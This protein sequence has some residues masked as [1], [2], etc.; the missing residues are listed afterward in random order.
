MKISLQ[1]RVSI[2]VALV[3]IVISCLSTYLFIS[4][5]SRSKEEGRI[6]RGMAL[7]YALSK[8]AEEGLVNEDLDLIKK[9]SNIIKSQDVVLVQVYSNI[10]ESIDSYPFSRLKELPDPEALKHFKESATPFY[11]RNNIGYD[12]YA[13][14][15][16]EAFESS[17]PVTIGFVRVVLSSATITKEIS[18]IIYTNIIVSVLL[19]LFAIVS[20]NILL[21]RL[22]IKPVMGLYKSVSMFKDGVR[23]DDLQI[24]PG[25]ADEIKGLSVE[26]NHMCKSIIEKEERL[27]ESDKRTRSLFER[28]EHGIFRLDENGRIIEANDRFV[29]MFG[30][31][32]DLC[33]ILVGEMTAHHCLK[34][35][36]DEKVFHIEDKAVG[37]Y[38]QE[39]SISLSLYTESDPDGNPIGFDGYLIDTTEKKRLE[40][41]LIRSQK[42]EAVGTL[43]GGMAHDFNNILTA[44]LGYSEIILL[45]TEEGSEFYKPASIIYEAA[46]RGADFGKKILALTRKE[47]L[48]TRSLNIN[49]VVKSS[50]EILQRSIH[51]NIEIITNLREEIPNIK[52][53]LSQLQQVIL[54]LAVNARDAM[55]D[56]GRLTIET[57]VV[58]DEDDPKA[59]GEKAGFVKLS[60]SDTG[61]GMDKATQ[62]HIFDPFFTTKDVG[63]GTGLGLYIVHSIVSN[64]GG[65]INFYSEPDK[66]TQF[67]I[68]LPVTKAVEPEE[69]HDAIN[70]QGSGTILVIDDETFIREMCRDMLQRLGYKV[71]LAENGPVGISIFREMKNEIDVVILDM[72][73]PVM[74]GNEVFHTLKIIKNDAKILLCSGY[75]RNGFAGIDEL[76]SQGASGFIQKPF[77]RRTMAFEIKKALSV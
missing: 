72:V 45:M 57:S 60:I 13:P 44:I 38:G 20:I 56:G 50:I 33:D 2:I 17:P 52:A 54:N 16:F 71:I 62:G 4:M 29:Q 55:L 24:M 23:P 66:G 39:I 59:A 46:K 26:F 69:A 19:T 25:S 64:H 47:K 42:M 68:Y 67:S 74:S 49:D 40:E 14:I 32:T 30:N 53:D 75:S 22:V 11:L 70:L 3:I 15:I 37:K 41:R 7:S 35:A 48:E 76:L 51:R 63:K 18:R 34:K 77:V 36:A 61:I 5:H 43:A 27:I 58:G 12:F 31:I 8:A 65:Y 9:A 10:W 73:M 6:I 21:R 1:T 28:V